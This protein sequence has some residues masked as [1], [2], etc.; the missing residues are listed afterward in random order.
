MYHDEAEQLVAKGLEALTNEH[1]YLALTCF[2]QAIRMEWGA[3]A[4]SCLAYCRA[5]LKGNYAEA[6]LLA[7]KALD[8]EPGNSLHYLNLGKVLLMA[9]QVVEGIGMLRQGLRH[10]E[11]LDIIKELERL[12]VRK[13]PI[14]KNLPRSHPLNR[15]PGIV[16]SRLGVR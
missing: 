1:E 3:T 5:K 6:I 2:E 11:N 9:G 16:L 14:F 8:A 7:R 10:G 15:Y 4:C 13:P 12:G